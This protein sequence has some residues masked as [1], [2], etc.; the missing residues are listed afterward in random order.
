MGILCKKTVIMYFRL[1]ALVAAFVAISI[2]GAF[3]MPAAP[4]GPPAGPPAAGGNNFGAIAA[5]IVSSIEFLPGLLAGLAYL[6]G[7]LIGTKAIIMMNKH[8]E[9]PQQNPLSAAVIHFAVG[10]ALFALPIV[11]EAMYET[12]GASGASVAAAT[13][14]EVAFNLN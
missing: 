7:I 5:N 1:T 2:S 6:M 11:F 8:V 14:S 9:S 4:A 12:I 10:G 3:A 13:L